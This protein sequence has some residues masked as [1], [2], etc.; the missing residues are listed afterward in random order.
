M[1]KN[2]SRCLC[3]DVDS[4]F[5]EYEELGLDSSQQ[6][7]PPGLIPDRESWA[8]TETPQNNL[9]QGA[10]RASPRTQGISKDVRNPRRAHAFGLSARVAVTALPALT[11]GFLDL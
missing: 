8:H 10:K 11:S 7:R 6:G 3:Q 9:S 5:R 2:R 1:W 4:P